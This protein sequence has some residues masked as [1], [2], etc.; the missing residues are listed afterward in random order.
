MAWM[1]AAEL[2]PEVLHAVGRCADSPEAPPVPLV[3]VRHRTHSPRNLIKDAVLQHDKR[4]AFGVFLY[5][6]AGERGCER[7][8]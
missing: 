4:A 7:V 8:A 3:P 1:Q 2:L 5:E 6:D